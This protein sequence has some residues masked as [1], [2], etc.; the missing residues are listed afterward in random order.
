M[1]ERNAG[2]HIVSWNPDDESAAEEAMKDVVGE[3]DVKVDSE[4]ASQI[5]EE[6]EKL[7]EDKE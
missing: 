5:R 1:Y 6:Y 7:T 3:V 2:T 4:T